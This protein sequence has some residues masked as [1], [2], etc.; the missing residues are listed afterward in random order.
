MTAIQSDRNLVWFCDVFC[1]DRDGCHYLARRRV[2]GT[3]AHVFL[4]G[5]SDEFN[6]RQHFDFSSLSKSSIHDFLPDA[7][8]TE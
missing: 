1:A 7:Q 2:E 4:N 6:V 3:K 5:P 8:V